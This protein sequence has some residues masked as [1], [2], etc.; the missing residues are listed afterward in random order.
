MQRSCLAPRF[1]VGFLHGAYF[2]GQ[3]AAKS[4]ARCIREGGC[5]G[6]PHVEQVRNAVPY[7]LN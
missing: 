7:N 2:E 3:D 5:L 1:Y 6:L 4:V